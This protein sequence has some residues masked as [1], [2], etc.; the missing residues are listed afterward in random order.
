MICK[1]ILLI[2]FFNGPT[3]KWFQALLCIT[4]NLIKYQSFVYTQLNDQT[5]LLQTIQLSISQQSEMLQSIVT[6]HKELKWRLVIYFH[7][8]KWSNSSISIYSI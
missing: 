3:V 5:L 7:A 8:G 2:T 4:N 1:R 6:Y